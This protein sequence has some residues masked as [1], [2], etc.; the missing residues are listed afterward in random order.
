MGSEEGD[1]PLTPPPR[2]ESDRHVAFQQASGHEPNINF[3]LSMPST[4]QLSARDRHGGQSPPGPSRH[5]S[6][7]SNAAHIPPISLDGVGSSRSA[8]RPRLNKRTTSSSA[9][10]DVIA[11]ANV[12]TTIAIIPASAFR[13]L[14]KI[15]PKATAHIV[16]VIL[17]RFQRVTLSQAFNYLGLTGEVLQTEK[18]MIKHTICQLPNVLRGDALT[19]L[20]EKFNRERERTGA[21]QENKGI[22]LHNAAAHRP[23]KSSTSLRKGAVLHSMTKQRPKSIIG[24]TGFAFQDLNMAAHAPSPGSASLASAVPDTAHSLLPTKNDRTNA[25]LQSLSKT[26][27]NLGL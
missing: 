25:F 24:P 22:A 8:P 27:S 13:R 5:P 19:R 21:G 1:T 26:A 12:D 7:G 6:Y 10:P 9:H 4:P 16:H 23:R 3:P 17:S 11:R 18:D 2:A 20:K 14:I 15:Y